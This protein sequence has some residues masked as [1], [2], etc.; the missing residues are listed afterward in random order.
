MF[1]LQELEVE[2]SKLKQDLMSL[3]TTVAENLPQ[4]SADELMS[5]H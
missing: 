5:K 1:Q 3:R 2:N 4:K